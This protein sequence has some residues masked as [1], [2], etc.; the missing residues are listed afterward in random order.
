MVTGVEIPER[1]EWTPLYFKEIALIGS[2]AFAIEEYAGR[3]QHAMEWYLEFVRTK[4]VDVH[5]DHHA[6]LLLSMSTAR[7]S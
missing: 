5:A 6:P 3:R 1:F 2:N 4:R 7:R